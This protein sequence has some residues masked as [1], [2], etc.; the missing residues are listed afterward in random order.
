MAYSTTSP[1]IWIGSEFD[2]HVPEATLRRTP[3]ALEAFDLLDEAIAK[4]QGALFLGDVGTGKT[5]ILGYHAESLSKLPFPSNRNPDWRWID[6]PVIWTH[7]SE[8]LRDVKFEFSAQNNRSIEY[9]PEHHVMHRARNVKYL[10]IDDLGAEQPT[11]FTTGEVNDLL[12]ERYRKRKTLHTFITTNLTLEQ[13]GKRYSER[14]PDRLMEM[15]TIVPFKGES[16][17]KG[18]VA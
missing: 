8:Y 10:F 3:H 12:D 18:R 6:N 16:Y 9:K 1:K 7:F 13:I 5:S 17:R 14:I 15:C 4:G 11:E 2:H